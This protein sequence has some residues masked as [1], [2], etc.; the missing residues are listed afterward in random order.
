M[1]QPYMK[2]LLVSTMAISF[3][4]G[5]TMLPALSASAQAPS[6]NG[7]EIVSLQQADEKGHGRHNRKWPI[8]EESANVIGVDK[9][10]LV[11]SLKSGKSI[12][13]AAADK[14]VSEADLTAKLQ[15]LRTGK[16]ELAVKDGKLT[17]DQGEHMKQKLGEHLKFILNEKNLLDSHGRSKW[18]RFGLK[19]DTEKL[20]KTLGLSKDELHAQLRSGKSLTEI[21]QSKG[22]SKDKLVASIK[23]QLTPSIEK[24]VDH[25]K[26]KKAKE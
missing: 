21:A 15:Q 3:V 24:W 5:A 2:K 7:Q 17:A 14:G 25:K 11:K 20:A 26:D 13:E 8:I 23:D 12:V 18:H 22:I 4:L 6:A 16:I 10:V 19:P 1:N 9:E